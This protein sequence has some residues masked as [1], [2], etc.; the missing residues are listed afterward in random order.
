MSLPEQ[1]AGIY[2]AND[3]FAFY[4]D[5]RENL[6][7][8]AGEIFIVDAYIDQSLFE[9]YLANVPNTVR[10]RVLTSGQPRANTVAVAALFAKGHPQ[11]ELRNA[12]ALHDRVVFVDDRCWVVG[13]SIKDA[14]VK[15]P[16][17]M[18][19]VSEGGMRAQYEPLWIN[20]TMVVRS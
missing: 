10:L 5:L 2:E 18:V 1:M 14:A 12:V 9:L 7:R 3:P 4:L 6:D 8:A 17:Y 16:T 15:K 20:A 11:F 13:Q 19:E